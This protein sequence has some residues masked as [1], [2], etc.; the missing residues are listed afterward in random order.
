M[1]HIYG[2]LCYPTTMVL[3]GARYDWSPGSSPEG[4]ID[5]SLDQDSEYIPMIWGEKDLT[6]ER[7]KDLA[8][9]GDNSPPYL[10]G[11]NEPN[12]GQQVV[13]F[14][15][16]THGL[17]LGCRDIFHPYSTVVT[18]VGGPSFAP[19]LRTWCR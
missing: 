10:L 4:I 15:A 11:F 9:A 7:L 17:V 8:L 18:T 2:V 5:A 19:H 1:N 16:H 3:F 13:I 6:D 14:Q 12:F